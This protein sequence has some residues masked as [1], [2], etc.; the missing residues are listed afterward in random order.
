MGINSRVTHINVYR[1]N[2]VEDL[3]R[4]VKSVNLNNSK[5]N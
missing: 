3:Y 1:K 5:E 4:L 2:K